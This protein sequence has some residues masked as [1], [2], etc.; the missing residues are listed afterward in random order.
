MSPYIVLFR[1]CIW[2]GFKNKSDT[3]HD[4]CEKLFMLAVTHRQAD[5]EKRVW[6]GNTDY[7]IFVNFDFDKTIFSILKV[8]R[9]RERLLHSDILPCLVY[10]KEGRCLET[11]RV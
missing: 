5:V 1:L 8:S 3:C 6:C 10:C 4:L 11:T 2:R 7:D 9:D